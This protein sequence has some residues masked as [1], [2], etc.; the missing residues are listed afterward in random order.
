MSDY[1]TPAQ[2]AD[3]FQVSPAFVY[4]KIHSGEWECTKLGNR[5]Y[6]FSE[7]QITAIEAGT[8]TPHRKTNKTRLRAA[9]KAIA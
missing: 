7:A 4:N 3:K 8:G 9:L 1:R 6:R 5:I 2:L